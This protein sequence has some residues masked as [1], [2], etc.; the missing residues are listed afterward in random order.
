[1]G[2]A[3]I[4][5]AKYGSVEDG[6]ASYSVEIAQAQAKLNQGI[7]KDY[8]RKRFCELARRLAAANTGQ[9]LIPK[10]DYALWLEGYGEEFSFGDED[11]DENTASDFSP[12]YESY[13]YNSEAYTACSSKV[14]QAIMLHRASQL[15][16]DLQEERATLTAQA[17][18]LGFPSDLHFL[19]RN[20]ESGPSCQT[21]IIQSN[22][23]PRMRDYNVGSTKGREFHEGWTQLL[24]GEV[25]ASWKKDCLSGPHYFKLELYIDRGSV[26]RNLACIKEAV[27]MSQLMHLSIDSHTP[28]LTASQ[29]KSLCKLFPTAQLECLGDLQAN[30]DCVY[31]DAVDPIFGNPSPDIDGGWLGLL[32]I[33]QTYA[34]EFLDVEDIEEVEDDL[35][36]EVELEDE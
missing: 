2:N 31:R 11:D 35:L 23:L 20:V 6:M 4:S 12:I 32:G 3:Q 29:Q 7:S 34:V 26:P 16:Y 28:A 22:G 8:Y 19:H 36:D 25:I 21:W 10:D 17:V 15:S 30:I 1:M 27:P 13:S 14:N 5:K 18:E 9:V 24:P 33:E